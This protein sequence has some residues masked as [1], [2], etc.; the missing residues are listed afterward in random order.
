M[1]LFCFNRKTYRPMDLS[2]A[3]EIN[4]Q[5]LLR[6]VAGL[7]VQ[8]GLVPGGS[9]VETVS[10]RLHGMIFHV[11]RPAESAVRRLIVMEAR[12]MVAPAYRARSGPG[13]PIARSKDGARIP[14]FP[15]FDPRMNPEPKPR[16]RS[17]HRPR[18]FFFDGMD[19]PVTTPVAPTPDDPV[20]AVALCRRLL[21]IRAALEDLPKQARRLVR[22]MARPSCKW[23][24]VMRYARPPGHRQDGKREIDTILRSLQ[25]FALWITEA[26][27]TG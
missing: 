10:R 4:R 26:P 22:A 9:L 20:S 11:L 21:S 7:F 25:T 13:G 19:E 8:L 16:R 5:A 6:I 27:D 17:G 2:L 1:F 23:K 15:L 3:I 12:E 24:R 14:A 18:I